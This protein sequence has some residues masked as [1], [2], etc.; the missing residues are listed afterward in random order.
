MTTTALT[1]AKDLIQLATVTPQGEAALDYITQAFEPL[2][3]RC[4]RKTFSQ[5]GTEDVDNL[6][7]SIGQGG[8]HFCF[9]G[10]VDVV[11]VGQGWDHN[12]FGAE[13]V[14][15]LLYGRGTC[16]MKG[17]IAA[18]MQAVFAFK[19]QYP[20]ALGTISLL[21]TS[22]EEGPAIN[23]TVKMLADM[24][25]KGLIP[26]VCLVGE[27]TSGTQLGDTVK[28][29]RRGSLCLRLTVQGKAGH[30]AYPHLAEDPIPGLGRALVAL[31]Q[32][33]LDTGTEGF[34]PS[35]LAFSSVA[36]LNQATNVIPGEVTVDFNIRFNPL[37][38]SDSLYQLID[39]TVRNALGNLSYALEKR[40][41]AVPFL[42]G[43]QPLIDVV[44]ESVKA[45]TGI[46]PVLSTSG[47]TSDARF[48]QAYCPVVELGP[49][50]ATIHQANEAISL[51]DL[52]TLTAIYTQCL[53]RYF[54]PC[55]RCKSS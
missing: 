50:N 15:G 23:G 29:G 9:A 39:E 38:S 30:V 47:G 10:H 27:P 37:H 41:Q 16:D 7:L 3:P 31:S 2:A 53:V 13:V 21:L 17:S 20:D 34:D 33:T 14:D 42:T 19:A 46:V 32:L 36:C 52:E 51:A 43:H 48:I 44:S 1:F 8:P 22:D 49:L 54:D 40:S 12:P 5:A 45:V 35:T 25:E 55:H 6:F 11:P 28:I 24:Q 18:F 4:H 26:D